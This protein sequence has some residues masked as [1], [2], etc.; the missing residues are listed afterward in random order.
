MPLIIENYLSQ[1]N[2]LMQTLINKQKLYNL[3]FSGNISLKE[4]LREINVIKNSEHK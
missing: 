4:Y 2:D 1:K 3:L